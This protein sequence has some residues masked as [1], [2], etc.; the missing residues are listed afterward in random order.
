MVWL[1]VAGLSGALAVGLGAAGA[2]AIKTNEQAY[3]DVYKT[4]STYHLVHTAPLALA[5]ASFQGTLPTPAPAPAPTFKPEP[6]P[7]H[8][9]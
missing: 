6:N 1:K 4:A 3:K 7:Q 9:A 2:H 5:A 8:Q